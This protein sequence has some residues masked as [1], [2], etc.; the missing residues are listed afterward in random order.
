MRV[1]AYGKK[2]GFT[3]TFSLTLRNK[4]FILKSNNEIKAHRNTID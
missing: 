2:D 1:L 4:E 3:A